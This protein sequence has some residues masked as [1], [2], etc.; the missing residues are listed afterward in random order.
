HGGMALGI[1]RIVMI[2]RGEE[3]VRE[4]TAFPKNQAARDV[5][6]DAPTPVPEQLVRDLHLRLAPEVR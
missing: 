1:D 6:M 2:A 3:N 4:I 5:M